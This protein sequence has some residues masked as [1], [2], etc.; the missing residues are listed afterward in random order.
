MGVDTMSNTETHS[1]DSWT[2]TDEHIKN[3]AFTYLDETYPHVNGC[4]QKLYDVGNKVVVGLVKA[5]IYAYNKALK[6]RSI[7]GK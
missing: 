3:M 6:D 5:F 1:D 7:M 4:S 2:I